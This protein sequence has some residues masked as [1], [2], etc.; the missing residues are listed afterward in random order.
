M[1]LM[2]DVKDKICIIVDDM[3][4]TGGT[5]L[6]HLIYY[7]KKEQKKYICLLVMVYFLKT[8]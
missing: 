4:D 5:A 2:G 6:K 1:A 3:I 7:I 8:H